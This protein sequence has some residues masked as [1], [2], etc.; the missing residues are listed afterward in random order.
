ML[1]TRTDAR[2]PYSG[3][4]RSLIEFDS[5][6]PQ[7]DLRILYGLRRRAIERIAENGS[8]DAL[9]IGAI[10]DAIEE[11]ERRILDAG[12]EGPAGATVDSG[13]EPLRIAA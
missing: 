1:A 12:A 7:D 9:R 4:I 3:G 8:N 13:L 5:M 2:H 10:A 11:R 6:T